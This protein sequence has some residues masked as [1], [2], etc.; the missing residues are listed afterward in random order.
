VIVGK[1]VEENE[2]DDLLPGD[3]LIVG[4]CTV[5]ENIDRVR[6]KYPDRKIY[7]INEC[8]DIAKITTYLGKLMKIK[9]L[10]M[11]PLSPLKTLG[12]VIPAKLHG[13]DANIP[14]IL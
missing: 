3:I 6:K 2:L 8:N 1:G 12:I 13:L 11:I 14:P 10:K 9:A 5:E 4:P 7:T